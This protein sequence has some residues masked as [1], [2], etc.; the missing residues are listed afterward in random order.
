M[1]KLADLPIYDPDPELTQR[2]SRGLSHCQRTGSAP[3]WVPSLGLPAVQ[4]RRH[5]DRLAKRVALGGR[6]HKE[7]KAMKSHKWS[8]YS[9]AFLTPASKKSSEPRRNLRA[10]ISNSAARR[11][12]A[13]I[14]LAPTG[15]KS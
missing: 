5:A 7:T 14:T 15:N 8:K 1:I 10:A 6:G 3:L 2:R 12:K 4:V 9:Q 11:K 13:P